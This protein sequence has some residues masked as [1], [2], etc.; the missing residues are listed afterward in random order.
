MGWVNIERPGYLGKKKKEVH[1]S[2]NERFG[3]GNWRLVY[4]WGDFV[5]SRSTGIQIYEDGYYEFFREDIETLDWLTSTAC[6]V[7]DT[8]LTNIH[9]GLDYTIQETPNSHIH[10]IA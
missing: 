3:E 2:W 1:D 5:V 6:D 9:S 8:A 10:D 7:Y 4:Q